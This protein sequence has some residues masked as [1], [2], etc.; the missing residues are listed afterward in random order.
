MTQNKQIS[1]QRKSNARVQTVKQ[2]TNVLRIGNE[3]GP[4]LT[5]QNATT[6]VEKPLNNFKNT[7]H[8]WSVMRSN[9]IGS[10]LA[11]DTGSL[12]GGVSH[13][14]S[15][16]CQRKGHLR[17]CADPLHEIPIIRGQTCVA[18]REKKKREEEQVRKEKL[19][20]RQEAV[21]NRIKAIRTGKGTHFK[22]PSR[23]RA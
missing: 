17:F 20:V 5:E 3:G 16:D 4:S 13:T 12:I 11:A 21:N 1:Q 8:H 19:P 6:P 10:V 15:L 9:Y 22:E 18:C 23:R 7:K 2:Y 14:P